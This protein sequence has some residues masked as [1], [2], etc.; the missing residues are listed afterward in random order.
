VVGPFREFGGHTM[1]IRLFPPYYSCRY[2]ASPVA[3]WLGDFAQ[4]LKVTGYTRTPMRGHISIL[5]WALERRAPV[6]RDTHFS[7]ADLRQ[8]FGSSKKPWLFRATQRVFERFLRSGGQWIEKPATERHA[9]L[10]DAYRAYLVEMRGLSAMS[11]YHHIATAR[12]FLNKAA[13]STRCLAEVSVKDTERFV[14]ASAQRFGHSSLQQR[15][16]YLRSFLRFCHDRGVVR[17]HLDA[18]DTP[19][20]YRAE[21]PPRAIPWELAQRLLASIDRSSSLGERDYAVLYLMTHY[22]LRTGEISSLRLDSIDWKAGELHV[23]Q[24]KTRSALA[25][26]LSVQAAAVLKRY[27]RRGRP[28]TERAELFLTVLAPVASLTTP[29]IG[30]MFRRRARQSGLPLTSSS[31]YGLRHGFALRLLEQG[32]GVKAIGDLLGHRSLESTCVYLRLHAEALRDV[33]L[34]VP[35]LHTGS[36]RMS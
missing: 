30:A 9:A 26:P 15:I 14:A 35:T 24:N 3:D 19:R 34:P 4:W 2:S 22:G 27:L 16:G 7:H 5:R 11:V 1:R 25:L 17:P 32:V 20:K 8:L 23:A 36:G 33:A 10:L 6:S 21:R 18:I 29:A 13:P 28:H 12:A 31:P